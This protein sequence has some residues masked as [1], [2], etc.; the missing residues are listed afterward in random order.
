M[1]HRPCIRLPDTDT[2]TKPNL[3]S[4][5]RTGPSVLA[6]QCQCDREGRFSTEGPV[7]SASD[8][9]HG[10]VKNTMPAIAVRTFAPM[11]ARAAPRAVLVNVVHADVSAWAMTATRHCLASKCW[12]A[13][14]HRPYSRSLRLV[15]V[16]EP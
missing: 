7:P 8:P 16:H 2:E 10:L 11:D 13:L 14:R 3:G 6:F 5:R 12:T 9:R 1:L 4:A 15:G